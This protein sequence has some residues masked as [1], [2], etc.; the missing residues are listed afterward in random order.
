M[1]LS[2]IINLVSALSLLAAI[3]IVWRM[4][5]ANNWQSHGFLFSILFIGLA[6]FR[7]IVGLLT[8]LEETNTLYSALEG[9]ITIGVVAL[10]LVI[11]H[12]SHIGGEERR[13]Q[14]VLE[15][16]Q[17]FANL[18]NSL[19]DVFIRVDRKLNFVLVN[20]SA[21]REFG[22][23]P[24]ALLGKNLLEIGIPVENLQ[25]ARE[26]IVSVLETGRPRI[27]EVSLNLGSS[28]QYYLTYGV[29]E[30]SMG[31]QTQ[32]ALFILRNITDK[33]QAHQAVR[34]S[35]ERLRRMVKANPMGM[36]F[37]HL[38]AGDRLVLTDYNP[39]AD[40]ILGISHA[41]LIGKTIE[42]AFPGLATT[43]VPASYRKLAREGGQWRNEHVQY[44][45][46]TIRGAF[47][48]VAFQISPMH[49]ATTFSDIT[50]RKRQEEALLLSEERMK[51]AV[52]TAK[53]GVWEMEFENDK[54]TWWSDMH[55]LFGRRPEETGETAAEFFRGIVVPEDMRKII[56]IYE[57]MQRK[58][59]T[60]T[61]PGEKYLMVDPPYTFR[62]RRP[63]NSEAV[64]IG[65]M[66]F[67]RDSS[68]N[69]T[70]VI[71]TALDITR[72]KQ[73]EQMIQQQ[74][75]ELELLRAIDHAIISTND[76][77]SC[78]EMLVQPIQQF[79]CA[80]LIEVLLYDSVCENIHYTAGGGYLSKGVFPSF[81][82][83]QGT[84]WLAIS[85]RQPVYLK[86]IPQNPT[87]C[88]LTFYKQEKIVSCY[89]VPLMTPDHVQGVIQVF[90]RQETEL[91]ESKV[92]FLST[93]SGQL[94]IA[95]EKALLWGTLQHTLRNLKQSYETSLETL[96]HALDLRDNETEHH[97]RRVTEL[98]IATALAL[99]VPPEQVDNIRRGALLHDVGKIGIPDT[100]LHKDGPLTDDEWIIMRQ[101]PEKAYN[102]LKK[103]ELF[104]DALDIPYCH[105]ERWDGSGYPQGL[106][107]ETIP[108]AARIFAVADV[109]DA[110]T[111]DR[112]YR[113]RWTEAQAREH[114]STNAGILFDAQVVEIFLSLVKKPHQSCP[115]QDPK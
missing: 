109:W 66:A 34:E 22:I 44:S 5:P 53:L 54:T 79:F 18:V 56:D 14:V 13:R 27:D 57:D 67:Q 89:S 60:E 69:F 49:M 20:S 114:I 23:A 48:V 78:V 108:L 41:E 59:R 25:L 102:L 64:M 32:T 7:L 88:N 4:K 30:L 90:F 33:A 115:G 99:G 1:N 38:E 19:P 75:E 36:H 105:H 101:H 86:N 28:P 46:G 3:T 40:T 42:E 10:A 43:E 77:K 6:G 26:I 73:A 50:H 37:Y 96:V 100:I 104:N 55:P 35:E 87:L 93:V 98:S 17:R 97:T 12:R 11:L 84:P 94:A 81:P 83:T 70:R 110:L 111:S 47:E 58:S 62:A 74:V 80:D 8:N 31:D 107:G 9:F 29:P 65:T 106:K 103:I 15:Q 112:P 39:S 51:L 72:Q 61:A 24:Q 92:E 63:D 91:E 76:V 16:E 21:E 85:S 82:V 45:E 52:R 68:G 113:K 71:G 95:V 2:D